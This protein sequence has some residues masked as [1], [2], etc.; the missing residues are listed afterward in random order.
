M[1]A[2]DEQAMLTL[3]VGTVDDNGAVCKSS[4]ICCRVQDGRFYFLLLIHYDPPMSN[5]RM[6]PP[7]QVDDLPQLHVVS[8]IHLV[9]PVQPDEHGQVKTTTHL[10]TLRPN[11]SMLLDGMRIVAYE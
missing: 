11:E 6:M 3:Q 8:C 2:G 10:V 5:A 7:L 9:Y 1:Q 4:T